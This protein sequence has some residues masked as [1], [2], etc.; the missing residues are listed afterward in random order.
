MIV[1]HNRNNKSYCV[2]TLD[3]SVVCTYLDARLIFHS[4][5]RCGFDGHDGVLLEH[6]LL[7]EIGISL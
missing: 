3:A 2:N 6:I 1:R 5:R 7:S 4:L